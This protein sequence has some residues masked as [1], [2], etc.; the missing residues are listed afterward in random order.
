LPGPIS[1]ALVRFR[2]VEIVLDVLALIVQVL[3]AIGTG[4]AIGIAMLVVLEAALGLGALILSAVRR[5]RGH[6]GGGSVV[7]APC[8]WSLTLLVRLDEA[9]GRLCPSVQLRGGGAL[10]HAWLRLELVDREGR[11]RLLRRKRLPRTAIGTELPL[12]AFESPAGTSPEEVLG[13]YWDIVIED[14]EGER[15]RWRERPRPVQ[16]LNAEAELT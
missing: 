4:A 3:V 14:K 2:D 10:T 6:H 11:V 13:W 16:R 5:V 12:P 1:A 15:A 8:A 7:E 9:S